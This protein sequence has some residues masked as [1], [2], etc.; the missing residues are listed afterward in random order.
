V[1]KIAE[2]RSLACKIV[3]L[4]AGGDSRVSPSPSELFIVLKWIMMTEWMERRGGPPS[5]RLLP[6]QASA[7]HSAYR[8]GSRI[9][10]RLIIQRFQ[11]AFGKRLKMP[12]ND[13]N[14]LAA[15]SK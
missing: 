4:V 5:Q 9:K 3:R 7:S 11:G 13:F 10:I 1:C 6:D 8:R 15:A 14:R 12:S 2:N